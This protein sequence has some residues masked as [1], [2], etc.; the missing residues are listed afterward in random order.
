MKTTICD[1]CGKREADRNFKIKEQ[2][3][4]AKMDEHGFIHRVLYW[5]RLDICKSCYEAFI[6]LWN[7][8][9]K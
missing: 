1:V 8:G 6:D 2:K 4:Y 3:A 9:D 7:G 5:E